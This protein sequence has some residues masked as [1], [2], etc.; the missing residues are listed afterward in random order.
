[1]KIWGRKLKNNT[2]VEKD[3]IKTPANAPKI[4]NGTRVIA[5]TSGKGGVGKTN[6]TV[7][8]G[9]ILAGMGYKVAIFDADLGM[10]NVD[11]LLGITSPL[12]LY[13]CIYHG[14]TI[15]EVIVPG[16]NGIQVVCG[17]SGFMEMANLDNHQRQR[18]LDSLSYFDRSADFVLIDTGAGI[19][20]D[21]LGFVAAASEVLLVVTPEPTSL[22][23]AYTLT[24][25]LDKYKLHQD[26]MLVIN[27]AVNE[28]EAKRTAQ[29]FENVVNN[30]LQMRVISLGHLCEDRTVSQS[31]KNQQPFS[32]DQPDCHSSRSLKGIAHYLVT[33]NH[34]SVGPNRG[35]QNFV[36]KLMRLFG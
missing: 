21:V 26:V 7:N 3:I 8:L 35:I 27:K 22:T 12:T 10:A 34:T 19:S 15:E 24:K 14:R 32:I 16:P 2:P 25:V 29:R 17:G 6:I 28:L 4:S 30:F 20:K 5:V 36:G 31:V 33:G 9:I 11:V 1:M 13:D 18:L 23:D